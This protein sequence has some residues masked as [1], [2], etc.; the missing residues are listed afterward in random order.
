ML[1]GYWPRLLA[2]KVRLG[3]ATVAANVEPNPPPDASPKP[4]QRSAGFFDRMRA[5]VPDRLRF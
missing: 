1:E 2:E 3:D 4:P 5:I